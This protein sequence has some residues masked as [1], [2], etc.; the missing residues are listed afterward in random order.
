VTSRR[1][2]NVRVKTYLKKGK[3][4]IEAFGTPSGV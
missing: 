4:L 2:G 1:Y 3:V